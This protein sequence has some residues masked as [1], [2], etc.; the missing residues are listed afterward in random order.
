MFKQLNSFLGIAFD[1]V[2][3]KVAHIKNNCEKFPGHPGFFSFIN[4]E[5]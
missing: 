2:H 1:D 3:N 5:M 4:M